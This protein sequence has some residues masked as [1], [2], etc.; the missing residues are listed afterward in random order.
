VSGVRTVDV[1]EVFATGVAEF[2][3]RV[4]AVAGRW[5]VP[6]VLPGW[7]VRE[8]VR[9][10]VEEDLWAPPLF[11]GAT[12][13]EMGD[14]FAG[15]LLGEDPVAAFDEAA[16]AAVT[17]VRAAGA[18]DATVHLSFGDHP[19]SEYGMQLAA[20]HLVHAWDLARSL[21]VDDRLD[22]AAVA[23]VADWFG[24][25]QPLYLQAGAIAAPVEVPA[26]ADRQAQLIGMTGRT[27]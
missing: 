19:G 5:D 25:V 2:A 4:H 10:V 9:H 1:T 23:V 24:G 16:A 20:D 18:M 21:G 7:T 12:I 15:D 3:T 11:S 27:P 6:S 22:P 17:A 14:R 8:L 26:D 13:A